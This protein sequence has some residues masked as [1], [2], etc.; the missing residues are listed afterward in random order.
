MRTLS[1]RLAVWLSLILIIVFIGQWAALR[2]AIRKVVE[3]QTLM[4]LEHD[5]D[6]LLSSLGFSAGGALVLKEMG[7]EEVYRQPFS[8]HY[9]VLHLD[10]KLALIS[11]SLGDQPLPSVAISPGVK[12]FREV[13]GPKGQLVLTLSQG[14]S[15]LNHEVS[16]TVG[17]DLT[18]MNEEIDEHSIASLG[19]ILP[20]LIAAVLMQNLTIRR[21]LQPL[22]SV[23]GEL[24]K[25]RHGELGRI[26]GEVPGE[27]RPLVDEVNRL[28]ELVHRRLYQ[29]RTAVGNLAHAIKTPLAV[30]FRIADDPSL[31]AEQ[32]AA[33]Q[34]QTVII[35]DRV[36]RELKRARL[37]GSDRA[38]TQV[39]IHAELQVMSHVLAS[40]YRDKG[41][42]IAID[43]PDRPI[44]YDREDILE[45][46][47]NLADNACKWAKRQVC[48][49]VL[50]TTDGGIHLRVA[51]DG[52]GCTPEMTKQLGQRGVRLDESTAGHGLGLAICQDIVDSYGGSL[53]IGCD[54]S[55]GGLTVGVDLPGWR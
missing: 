30:L 49:Q 12:S 41:L 14:H 24:E 3:S 8:G 2:Y 16:I 31:P 10:K 37:A 52:P 1:K 35:R 53:K 29:S 28:L 40:I 15:L 36:E 51:D 48:I 45:L 27:I 7:V 13:T 11:P 32:S 47:G 50:E 18:E 26:G 34:A 33:L 20:L 46:L 43:A 44:P 21:E 55:L 4:H 17:E 25:I 5:S 19:L 38:G 23:K 9:Y 6:A 54:Q 22:S 39:D 42:E